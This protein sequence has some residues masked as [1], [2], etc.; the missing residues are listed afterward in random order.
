MAQSWSTSCRSVDALWTVHVKAELRRG[1]EC[2]QGKLRAR[3]TCCNTSPHSEAH[4]KHS[5]AGWLTGAVVH[6]CEKDENARLRW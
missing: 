4:T 6:T 2:M 3:R 5:S 1:V